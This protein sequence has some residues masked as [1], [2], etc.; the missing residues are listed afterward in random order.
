MRL[1]TGVGDRG[2]TMLFDGR[3]VPKDDP[4]V[5][6]YGQLDALNSVLGWCRCAPTAAPWSDKIEQIQRD[7]FSLGAELATP[8]GTKQSARVP[9]LTLAASE[10]LEKWIDECCAHLPALSSFVLPGGNELAARLHIARTTCRGAERDVV[11]LHR[12]ATLRSEVLVYI[13]RLS[14]LLFAWARQANHAAGTPDT[15]WKP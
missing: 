11:S 10:R 6:A 9:L 13:N 8:A 1:Y 2:E 3:Q 12:L 4:R 14:D 5:A 7:L 15:L